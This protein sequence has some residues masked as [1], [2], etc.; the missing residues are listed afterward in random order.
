MKTKSD[1]VGAEIMNPQPNIPIPGRPAVVLSPTAT[2]QDQWLARLA[3]VFENAATSTPHW[4][5]R[6]LARG[7]PVESPEGLSRGSRNSGIPEGL[8]FGA[9]RAL[10]PVAWRRGAD[11]H[12]NCGRP[13]GVVA[14]PRPSLFE[15][16]CEEG[17]ALRPLAV[18]SDGHESA[19]CG[20]DCKKP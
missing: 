20:V 15:R 5:N 4:A 19:P 14:G 16:V 8:G 17:G 2:I 13:A 3:H 9:A 6:D 18:G 1:T 10:V 7:K 12:A 11:L